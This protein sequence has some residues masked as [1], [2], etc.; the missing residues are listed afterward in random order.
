[1]KHVTV[2]RDFKTK[3]VIY[4]NLF[5]VENG[6][7]IFRC[8]TIENLSKAC[9]SGKF[10]LKLEYSPRFKMNLWEVY[11]TPGR[12][13]IKIHTANYWQQLDGCIGIGQKHQDINKDGVMDIA[14]SK[15]ALSEFHSAMADIK[16]SFITVVD[17]G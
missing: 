14:L 7:I 8:K 15:A 13:E 10:P 17:V 16:E 3:E 6:E 1:M 5:V 9:P 2:L 11:E 4:G 12:S